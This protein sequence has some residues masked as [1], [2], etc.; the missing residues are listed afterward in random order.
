MITIVL[1]QINSVYIDEKKRKSIC[2]EEIVKY[3]KS[4]EDINYI[5]EYSNKK[6]TKKFIEDDKF[7]MIKRKNQICAEK[8]SDTEMIIEKIISCHKEKKEK[9]K[10]NLKKNFSDSLN[11][12]D[13]MIKSLIEV[14][15]LLQ[16]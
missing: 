12:I 1:N 14:Y 10:I 9:F 7:R 3:N 2:N 5:N 16:Y 6:D 8:D 4:L 11:E 13:N 15:I